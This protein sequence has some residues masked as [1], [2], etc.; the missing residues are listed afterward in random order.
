MAIDSIDLLAA[1]SRS[2]DTLLTVN[3]CNYP[4]KQENIMSDIIRRAIENFDYGYVFTPRNFPVEPRK[5][6]SVNRLLNYMVEVGE[7]CRI[8]KGRFY[9]PKMTEF[10]AMKP[11]TYEVVKDLLEKDGKQ[12][13]YLTGYSIFN[14]LGLTT[15]MSFIL[16]IG[17][18][19][20]K[21]P[22]KR[23][24]Y[25]IHFIKQHNEITKENVYLLKLLDCLRF[26]R[27]IPDSMP[28]EKCSRIFLLLKKI[29]KGQ[30]EEIKR[31]SLK[32]TPQATALLG[33]MLETLNPKENTSEMY[34]ML[35][36]QSF[37]KLGISENILS[38]QKK[39][40]IR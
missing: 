29:T 25:R 27:N 8:S 26:F 2:D 3:S 38:N 14:E 30:K 22:I 19:N 24:L 23:G 31:L 1:K 35:N 11:N 28:D 18:Q 37:Y 9:K 15:Q 12:I 4:Q 20:E 21:N 17:I 16:Q 36:P 33:A 6:A 7:I 40:N 13:G 10:G 5:A 32:Y 39:W 34:N